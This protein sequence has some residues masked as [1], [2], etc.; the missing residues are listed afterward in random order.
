M[1]VLLDTHILLWAITEDKKFPAKADEI[2]N[3]LA[4][5]I[6]YSSISIWEVAIK[7]LKHPDKVTNLPLQEF[8]SF[9]DDADFREL[10]FDERT[11]IRP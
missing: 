5:E 6:Y 2:I 3:N 11:Y 8:V 4:N 9:C 1:R 10:P 7:R